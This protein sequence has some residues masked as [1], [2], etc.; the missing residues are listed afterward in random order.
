MQVIHRV[1]AFH[2]LICCVVVG[3]NAYYYTEYKKIKDEVGE[4]AND[5]FIKGLR[6]WVNLGI[7]GMAVGCLQLLSVGAWMPL[8]TSKREVPMRVLRLVFGLVQCVAILLMLQCTFVL[9][10]DQAFGTHWSGYVNIHGG[11][12]FTAFYGGLT[13]H[14]VKLGWR[15]QKQ[16]LN[17]SVEN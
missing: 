11:A 8:L 1:A 6:K 3:V 17:D 4:Y 5:D 2:V 16:V 13:V 14:V 7:I 10:V 9:G 15:K 12:T